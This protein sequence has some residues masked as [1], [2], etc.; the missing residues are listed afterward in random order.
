ML[1]LDKRY[2]KPFFVD[3]LEQWDASSLLFLR[4]LRSIKLVDLAS[5]RSL[6][7]HTLKQ[8]SQSELKLKLHGKRVP[9][10]RVVLRDAGGSRSWTRYR[11]TI[12]TVKGIERDGE[13]ETGKTTT[14]AVA[15]PARPSRGRL[16]VGFRLA[17]PSSLPFSLDAQFDPDDSRSRLLENDWNAWLL[18]E[19]GELVS[20]VMLERF[21]ESP[22]RGWG[23]VPRSTEQLGEDDSWLRSQGAP[24]S[25]LPRAACLERLRLDG[26][27]RLALD[28]LVYESGELD[29]M[30][31]ED[32]L[33]ALAPDHAA[34]RTEWRD[35]DGRWREVMDDLEVGET[36]DADW[37]LDRP[38]RAG[39]REP[40]S[41]AGSSR[42]PMPGWSLPISTRPPG[43]SRATADATLPTASAVRAS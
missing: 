43:S 27:R 39:L 32:E 20:A 6:V 4:Q 42:S 23:L 26:R 38:R 37:L 11:V 22:A 17:E 25:E 3:W 21:G 13:K 1:D 2:G 15:V 36:V 33:E 30:L 10:E 24:I 35:G 19:L 34:L 28:D 41:R 18:G 16:H 5:G 7:E 14:I 9:A 40:R 29:K 8:T 31:S 12:P